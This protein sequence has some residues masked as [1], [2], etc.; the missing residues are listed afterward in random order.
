MKDMKRTDWKRVLER[1]T[2]IENFSHGGYTGKISI[3]KIEKVNAPLT[4][5]YGVKKIRI[6]DDGYS[7]VQLALENRYFWFT[8]MF[9][10]SDRLVEIYVDLTD[11]NRTDT[12]NPCFED[13]Y[14][15]YVIFDG[16]VLELDRDELDEAYENGAVSKVQYER[17]LSEGKKIEEYLRSHT[18]E[19]ERFL[20][21]RQAEL[22]NRLEP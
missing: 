10:E 22:K 5:D 13:M 3:L 7:W 21:E 2:A 12:E 20:T 17:T 15:D 9:D 18:A 6:A 4:I 1:K 8:A 16:A 11:G 14:L 19:L